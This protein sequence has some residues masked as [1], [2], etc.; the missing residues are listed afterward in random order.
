[1]KENS[2]KDTPG[3]ASGP[4]FIRTMGSQ[5]LSGF[6]PLSS[7]GASQVPSISQSPNQNLL[8]GSVGALDEVEHNDVRMRSPS[9]IST[10]AGI[11]TPFQAVTSQAEASAVSKIGSASSI[12]SVANSNYRVAQACDRCRSKKTRCDGKRP[13]CSQCAAVG[14]ECKISD[15]LSRRAFP[16]GYTETLEERVRELEAENRRL[17]ALCDIKEQQI[18]LVSQ[19]SSNKKKPMAK[20]ADER[21]LQEL[22]SANGGSLHISSTNLFLLNKTRDNKVATTSD[23]QGERNVT[24]MKEEE[25][26]H[27][28]HE[29][30][31]QQQHICDGI[32]CNDKLHVKPVSTN[33]NDPTS[34]SFEQNEA[35][36]LPAVKALTSMATRE[37]STQLATLVALSVPRSTEEILFIPQ[38]LAR[39]RQI[40]GFT[41][42]QC[43]YSVSLL[44]SLKGN[45]PEP[46]LLGWEPLE[47]LKVDNLWEIDDLEKF[48]N[49]TLKFDIIKRSNKANSNSSA[50][51]S[52]SIQEIDELINIFFEHWSIHIPILDKEEFFSYYYKFKD[53]IEN[54]PSLFQSGPSNFA[55]RNKIISYKIFACILFTL[56]QMGLLTK[57][58]NENMTTT[59]KYT[60][61]ISYYHH[62]ISLIYLNPYFGVLT[63][64]LQSLQF[65][66]LLLFYFLNTGNVSAIYELRGRVVSMAQQLR[67]HRCPSA[68]L[69]GSGSTMNKREQGD[70]RVL[71]WGIYNLDVFSAL[72]LGVPRLLKDFEIE[73]ALPVADNDN[74]KVSLAGQM[75]RLEGHVSQFSLAIIRFAKVLGNILDTIFKR[76]MTESIT[77]QLALVHE[78]ALDNWRRGLPSEFMFELD[79]N[80]T[81]NMDEFNRLKQMNAT[82]QNIE[83]MVLQIFYFLAKCMIHLPVVATRRLPSSEDGNRNGLSEQ[84]AHSNNEETGSDAQTESSLADRSSSSYVLLQQAT[85]TMLNVLESLKTV[86]LPLPINVSRTKARFALLSARGSLEYIKG[87]ALFL[88]NKALLLD[89]VKDLEQD[90][91]LEIP[92]V[93][94]WH[95]L[96]LLD[97]TISLLLQPASTKVEKLDKLLKKK[98]NYYNRLMGRPIIRTSS[99]KQETTNKRKNSE[100]EMIS[101]N[102]SNLSIDA[103]FRAT[104]LTPVS[105]KSDATPPEKR[106]K[107]EDDSDSSNLGYENHDG[108]S[109]PITNSAI[110]RRNDKHLA[111]LSTQTAIAE[112]LQLDPVLNSNIFSNADLVAFFGGNANFSNNSKNYATCATKNDDE[113]NLPHASSAQANANQGSALLSQH[114]LQPKNGQGNPPD[115]STGGLDGLFRV[116][117]SA[118]FLMDEYY[119]P[120]NSQL[121]LTLL[122]NNGNNNINPNARNLPNNNSTLPSNSNG[123]SINSKQ[124][125]SAATLNNSIAFSHLNLNNL[126]GYSDGYNGGNGNPNGALNGGGNNNSSGFNFAVDASLGLAPL[127]AWSPEMSTHDNDGNAKT[128]SNHSDRNGII[129]DTTTQNEEDETGVNSSRRNS[130]MTSPLHDSTARRESFAKKERSY[131]NT[132]SLGQQVPTLESHGTRSHP[133]SQSYQ[134]N[135][136]S[137][138]GFDSNDDA[139]ATGLTLGTRRGPRRRQMS[140]AATQNGGN[141][142]KTSGNHEENLH[143]LFRW[144]NSK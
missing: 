131:T 25:E 101:G 2:S 1:M 81:I 8:E 17:V 114:Q 29:N 66:S 118:D 129:L 134:E 120:G 141:L 135:H 26:E 20:E 104:N 10:T 70:R 76:G 49:E 58:K 62:A 99:I 14:F 34:V 139:G 4:K 61:L 138:N 88:D 126:L 28:D 7:N 71:F 117:S 83:N 108:Y 38:L 46:Q 98:L 23:S 125:A 80:G 47:H 74:T 40:H 92:G 106:I 60:K 78:N 36:G 115:G 116:P 90:R 127:L 15:K 21:M 77:K 110:P 16:R 91:K 87:G 50:S 6:N 79:V 73:C 89:V 22:R 86:Y 57:V 144:Q 3:M 142:N 48:F 51:I 102:P 63:T 143:N 11:S 13:Q 30:K 9:L 84:E 39:I 123:G 33:L 133:L 35:P 112:A 96:K 75:I 100:D 5:S 64:S 136:L 55:R 103:S 56:C 68:V 44:S 128:I 105:S 85:N 37:Q 113:E 111:P 59:S 42:K 107:L 119:V 27:N 130:N 12:S 41:S 54:Q 132:P 31:K 72:Q 95:S 65:L 82:V 97:M 19:Y 94:S 69:G 137:T 124:N 18:H 121:N 93:I 53:D 45:L 43:L 24:T 122:N 109:K 140:Y 67:L 52:L 32:D